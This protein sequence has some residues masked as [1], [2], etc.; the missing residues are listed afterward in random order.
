MKEYG[1]MEIFI[2][3]Q[4]QMQETGNLFGVALQ[5]KSPTSASFSTVRQRFAGPFWTATESCRHSNSPSASDCAL[6]LELQAGVCCSSSVYLLTQLFMEFTHRQTDA[7]HPLVDSQFIVA[8]TV[9]TTCHWSMCGALATYPCNPCQLV[10]VG[11]GYYG[12]FT[13]N[14]QPATVCLIVVEHTCGQYLPFTE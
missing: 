3:D 12:I 5:C 8:L 10:V 1:I 11:C 9:G 7:A 6:V 2:A 13:V 4:Q 14:L